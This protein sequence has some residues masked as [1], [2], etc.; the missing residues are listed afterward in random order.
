MVISKKFQKTPV[1]QNRLSFCR[2]FAA[3]TLENKTECDKTV[4]DIQIILPDYAAETK[5]LISSKNKS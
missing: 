1:C 3:E 5:K 4:R 2:E